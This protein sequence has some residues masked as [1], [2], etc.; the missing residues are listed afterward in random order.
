MPDA[1]FAEPRLAQLYDTLDDDRSDLDAY[2]AM[3]A[4]FGA[5]RVL[6]IGCGTGTL[7]CLLAARGLEVIGADPAAASLDVARSKPGAS[8]VRWLHTAAAGLPAL[9]AD[10][11]VMTG[12]VA[13]VFVTDQDWAAALTAAHQ[14]LR[15]G[16]RLV[17]ETRDPARQAWRQ[18]DRTR[19]LVIGGAGPVETWTELLAAD[20]TQVSF[21]TTFH[22]INEGLVLTS[23]ST[24]RFRDRDEITAALT[25]AGFVVDEIR[26]APDRPG[27]EFVFVTRRPG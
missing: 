7:A 25:A 22:F 14:A 3:T 8:Q 26:D 2:L 16:G 19:R 13:Q 4:E 1:I 12:N 21:Q 20:A 18:W 24:L 15:P 10:L 5:R 9:D 23:R 11:A 17:F 27:L 6:D